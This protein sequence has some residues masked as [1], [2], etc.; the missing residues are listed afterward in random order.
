[1]PQKCLI[2]CVHYGILNY[3]YIIS[4]GV[5]KVAADAPIRVVELFA[6]VGGFRVGLE[7]SSSRFQTVWANQWEPG[8]AGQWAYKCYTRNFGEKS[9]CSNEDIAAVIDQVPKH[10]YWSAVFPAKIIP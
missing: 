9:F 10:D 6:G 5:I 8:Q 1:M 2:F 4:R 3:N 7:R